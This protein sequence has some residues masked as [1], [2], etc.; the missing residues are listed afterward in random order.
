MIKL[1]SE[2]EIQELLKLVAD[3]VVNHIRTKMT[4]LYREQL[5]G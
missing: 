5:N 1:L 3:M 4:G 2:E